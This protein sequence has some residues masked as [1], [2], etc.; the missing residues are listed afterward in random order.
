MDVKFS[1]NTASLSVGDELRCTARGNPTPEITLSP[2]NLVK[3]SKSGA[4]WRSLAVQPDWVGRTLTV[5][6]TAANSVDGVQYSPSHS[7]TFNVTGELF[8]PGI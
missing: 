7:V 5:E 1:P 3:E 6:C 4:N 8:S 2:A